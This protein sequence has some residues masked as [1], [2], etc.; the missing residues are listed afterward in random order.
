MTQSFA[1][2]VVPDTTAPRVAII[3][4]YPGALYPWSTEPA[5]VRVT[6]TDDVGVTGIRVLVDGQPV[7]LRA[8][9]TFDVYF[10]GPGNGRIQAFA[11]DAAGNEGRGVARINER[12][13]NEDGSGNEAAAPTVA[14]TNIADDDQ[15]GGFVRVVGTA[16]SPDL[17]HFTLSVRR[18][19]QAAFTVVATGT[20]SVTAGTL[21][22][23]DTTLLE[24]DAYV[25]KLEAT[26]IFGG[27]A[28]VERS[29]G[30]SGNLKLGDFRLGFADL[31]VPVAG[32]PVT[33]ARTYDTLRAD[34]PGDFGAGWRLE[35][36]DANLRVGLAKSGL[37]DLGIYTPFKPGVKVYLTL[38]GGTR[39]GFTFTP[40]LR[41][42]PGFGGPGLTVATP[43][44]TPDRGVRDT[45]SVRGG[46][47][48]VNDTGELM[49]A[50]GL[51]WNPADPD[52]GGGYTV[53]TPD[54]TRYTIDGTTGL[55][56]SAA[57]ANGNTLTFTDAGVTS[58]AGGVGVTFARDA[59][60]PDHWPPPTR[61]GPR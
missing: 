15:V 22:T 32:L 25:L 38:P 13:G 7:A 2:G 30:V 41:T 8:D 20:K 47:L 40:D 21:G 16:S 46:T 6:A 56:G 10:T 54:G 60:R 3:A 31:T 43:H 35:Y 50:G 55:L 23:W 49:A 27:Y 14:V 9:G 36:R 37:E 11:V 39:E 19:D 51:P 26:D 24:N 44:F 4:S 53:T 45:L 48:L 57:D 52:F 1:V 29:V 5:R 17:D 59:A 33:V 61:P 34:R 12:S 58:S 42:L 28:A 18:V